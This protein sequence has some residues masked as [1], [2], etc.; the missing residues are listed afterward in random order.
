MWVPPQLPSHIDADAAPP[1][2]RPP[3]F[4][5]IPL[6]IGCATRGQVSPHKP[7]HQWLVSDC[8]VPFAGVGKARLNG[9]AQHGFAE[10]VASIT[11]KP[12]YIIDVAFQPRIVLREWAVCYLSRQFIVRRI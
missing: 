2:S 12:K 9:E 7:F 5:V 3:R 1:L 11:A 10:A 4:D 8:F 6:P